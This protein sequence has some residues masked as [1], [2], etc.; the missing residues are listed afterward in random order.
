MKTQTVGWN[1]ETEAILDIGRKQWGRQ[2]Q[3]APRRHRE[4]LETCRTLPGELR[5]PPLW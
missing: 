3:L 2:K 5:N 1:D 4:N